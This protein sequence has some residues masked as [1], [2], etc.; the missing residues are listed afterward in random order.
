MWIQITCVGWTATSQVS[1]AQLLCAVILTTGLE[2]SIRPSSFHQKNAILPHL[3]LREQLSL[4]PGYLQQGNLFTTKGYLLTMNSKCQG[5]M[6]QCAKTN[7]QF[8]LA[9][10][11]AAWVCTLLPYGIKYTGNLCMAPRFLLYHQEMVLRG[12]QQQHSWW[13]EEWGFLICIHI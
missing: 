1:Q 4:G 5:P 6:H 10:P 12:V 3:N 9:H 7:V 2:K 11:S 8:H 13:A